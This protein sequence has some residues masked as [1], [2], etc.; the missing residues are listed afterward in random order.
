[1]ISEICSH[2]SL[3]LNLC[4]S[5][6]SSYTFCTRCHLQTFTHSSRLLAVRV[7]TVIIDHFEEEYKEEKKLGK[8][9]VMKIAACL[10]S[11]SDGQ[12]RARA[13]K[14]KGKYKWQLSSNNN[15]IQPNMPFTLRGEQFE[16]ISI[17][18]DFI[19]KPVCLTI[20]SVVGS[21]DWN[22]SL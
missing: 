11:N 10:L 15:N 4:L 17:Y 18:S 3:A 16:E 21:L 13:I 20:P 8:L 12:K 14:H 2:P 7:W 22:R 19:N 5:L 1:M 6:R 9:T